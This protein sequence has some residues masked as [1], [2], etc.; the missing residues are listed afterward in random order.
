MFSGFTLYKNNV[1]KDGRHEMHP[2]QSS[3]IFV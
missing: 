1:G 2:C 3:A